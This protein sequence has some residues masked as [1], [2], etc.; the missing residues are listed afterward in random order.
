VAAPARTGSATS[1]RTSSRPDIIEAVILLPENLFYNT[2]S[3]G[4]VMLLNKTKR[5][6][7][8]IL[9]I[10]ASKQFDKRRPKNYLTH[11]NIAAI[12]DNYEAW[13]SRERLSAVVTTDEAVRNDF[14]LSPSRY[15][16]VDGQ[17]EVLPLE[18]AVVL[19]EEAEEERTLA[20]EKVH[21][22]LASLGLTSGTDT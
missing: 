8:Q 14:N 9:L 15:V 2:T 21:A 12:A 1:A 18:D 4:I 3:A 20:D 11:E 19:L 17:V 6:P 10:N 7:G 5:N 22:V 13:E 16:T